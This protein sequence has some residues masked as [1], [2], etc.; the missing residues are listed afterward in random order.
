MWRTCACGAGAPAGALRLPARP[1]RWVLPRESQRVNVR[2]PPA[3]WSWLLF[4]RRPHLDKVFIPAK[5]RGQGLIRTGHG[6][7][8]IGPVIPGTT[9]GPWVEERGIEPWIEDEVEC[10]GGSKPLYSVQNSGRSWRRHMPHA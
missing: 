2:E 3:S 9:S 4:E 5:L 7:L 8:R 1:P 10:A 6:Q